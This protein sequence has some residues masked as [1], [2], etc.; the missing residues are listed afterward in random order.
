MYSA[1]VVDIDLSKGATTIKEIDEAT[2]KKFLGGSGL[3][4][5]IIWDDTRATTDPLSPENLFHIG[6]GPL[7]G[8]TFPM[9]S[10]YSV[11]ALSPL[12][13]IWGEA[14]S[15]GRWGSELGHTGYQSIILR[16]KAKEPVYIY[17]NDDKVEIRD[18][19][20]LWG[21]DTYETS[22]LI[23]KET[24]ERASVADIGPS[25]ER[26]NRLACI[27]NDGWAGRS[28]ARCGL[29][30]V[31]GSKNVKA[32]AVRGT[33]R[34]AV[35]EPEKFRELV[36]GVM[37]AL[38]KQRE[39]ST[40]PDLM[41]K[42]IRY[43]QDH[44]NLP[45][46]NW[47]MGTFES[48]VKNVEDQFRP[49][50][51]YYCPTCT[52]GSMECHVGKRGREGTWESLAPLG[53]YCLVDDMEA[54]AIACEICNRWGI[55][56]ISA[57]AV[58]AFAME[59]YENGL[60]TR[61][62][63]GGIDLTWGNAGAMVKMVELVAKGEGFGKT[64]SQGARSAAQL[65][66]GNAAD[67]AI[68]VKGL[69]AP[70]H[71]PRAFHSLALAY[72]TSSRGA[73]HVDG[74]PHPVE[75]PAVAI[76]PTEMSPCYAD[77][78]YPSWLNRLVD[79]GKPRLVFVMQ[80]L[81]CVE[82]AVAICDIANQYGVRPTMLTQCLNYVTGWDMTLDDLLKSGEAIFNMKRLISVRRGVTAKDDRL[83]DRLL[84]YKRAD[85]G[86]KERL[87][88]LKSML[89]EYYEIRGWDANGIPRREKLLE[90]GL[91]VPA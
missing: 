83:P 9:S 82:N 14:H 63:T 88:D 15:G 12:T 75:R 89:E 49:E 16:G 2:L 26:L 48:F 23:Q 91:P 78:G 71:D 72:A 17:V 36:H 79:E 59:C 28:A 21:K 6:V 24:D 44:G 86:D 46:K 4:S 10:R 33:R 65:I 18:A 53:S 31:M 42:F 90:L 52:S 38:V 11:S 55:D 64:L 8:T 5:K 13:G 45:V 58:V 68:E 35:K 43:M 19:G 29:G 73:C 69:E 66:G 57:G 74:H 76:Q 56:T 39:R 85:V 77:L 3:A 40:T 87:P 32:I 70:A 27:M 84:S 37:P 30:A 34:P 50:K 60:I 67:Y 1:R 62:D 47:K 7:S 54:L 25:G 20:H 41:G 61:K 80:N 22:D 81:L 51:P